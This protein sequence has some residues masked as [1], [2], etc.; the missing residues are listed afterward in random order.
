[1]IE[2]IAISFGIICG[3]IY[4]EIQRRRDSRL[5][6]WRDLALAAVALLAEQKKQEGEADDSDNRAS[7]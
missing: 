5:E 3:V 2:I 7:D 1:M 6:A 4:G